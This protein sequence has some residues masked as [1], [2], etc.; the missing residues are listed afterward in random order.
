MSKE[1]HLGRSRIALSSKPLNEGRIPTLCF[2]K[3]FRKALVRRPK[4]DE[5]ANGEPATA[6][7]SAFGSLEGTELAGLAQLAGP[8]R[9]FDRGDTVWQEDA[10]LPSLFVLLEGWMVSRMS[11]GGR[12]D[13]TLKV[14]LPGDVLGLPSLAFATAAET[15]VAI[16]PVKL[17][18]LSMHS[19]GH[20]FETHPRVAAMMFLVSQQ[21]RVDLLDRLVAA[22]TASVV[23]RVA[24]FVCR[25]LDRVKRSY[26]DTADAFFLPMT[27][28]H[29][30]DIVG[31][32]L[33]QLT[34]AL[35]ELRAENI[36]G[37]T[38]QLLTVVDIDALRAK[39]ELP[40]RQLAAN[41][42]WLPPSSDES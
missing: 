31:T 13:L 8:P 30:A 4:S 16:T 36:L 38:N 23:Q 41:A 12:R 19:F 25:L 32:S 34:N 20:L 3:L 17:C 11:S 29:V 15:T 7:L 26:P 42:H 27:R 2:D 22:Q 33:P 28:Q 9:E 24:A 6:R 14:H 18:P 21:E 37:W 1:P 35:K 39:A 10:R 5:I 40:S